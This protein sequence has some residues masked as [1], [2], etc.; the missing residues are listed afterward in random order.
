MWGDSQHPNEKIK[1]VDKQGFGERSRKGRDVTPGR[2]SGSY[3]VSPVGQ[4]KE[5]EGGNK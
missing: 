3:H 4:E 1:A 2:S 5:E